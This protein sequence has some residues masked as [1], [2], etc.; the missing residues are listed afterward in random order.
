M[1]RFLNRF[2]AAVVMSSFVL[3]GLAMAGCD[4]NT[5]D[6]TP[7]IYQT[8]EAAGFTTLVA[9]LKAAGL[10]DVLDSNGPF[11]VFAPTDEAFAKLPEGTIETL[12]KPE[13]KD[14][15]VGILTYH[16]VEGRVTSGQVV[17]L[18]SA[19]TLQGDDIQISVTD[20]AVSIN[21]AGVTAV[22]IE[23]SNGI[24]HVID[25]VLLPPSK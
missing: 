10:A 20:G 5:D 16:V 11:T 25:T 24:V 17:N 22:D 6:P 4:S 13:N 1:T 7:S 15:L 9:A 19:K 12:L 18:T 8:A 23:A 3:S 2:A 21:S 14:M